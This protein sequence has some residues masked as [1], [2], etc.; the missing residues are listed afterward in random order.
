MIVDNDGVYVL[1]AS[2]ENDIMDIR[3][4]TNHND[5]RPT[6]SDLVIRMVNTKQMTYQTAIW[7][8]TGL[9][10]KS[11]RLERLFLMLATSSGLVLTEE[12][13]QEA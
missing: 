9:M 6:P 1:D 11:L 3:R 10:I 8:S 4:R 2:L 7:W 13:I 12:A 5:G